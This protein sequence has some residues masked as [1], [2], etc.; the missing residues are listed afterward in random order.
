M[1]SYDYRCNACKRPFALFFKSVK[2]YDPQAEHTCPHCGSTQVT[3]RIRRVA[4]QKPGRDLSSL[5]S[6]DMLSVMNTGNSREIGN[7][8]QQVADST[9]EDMG[10]EFRDAA[11]RLSKGE[12]LESVERDLSAGDTGASGGMGDDF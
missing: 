2:E 6:D 1:P 10:A 5:S 7:M 9:G 12:S 8:F 3:R 4:I 11:E